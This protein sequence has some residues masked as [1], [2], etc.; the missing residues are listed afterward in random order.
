MLHTVCNNIMYLHRRNPFNGKYYRINIHNENKY[1]TYSPN[2]FNKA[3][4]DNSITPMIVDPYVCAY[5]DTRFS[6]RNKLFY[7]LGYMGINIF[8][9]RKIYFDNREK[10]KR[11]WR[12]KK[13]CSKND[14]II[15][16]KR[17][18]KNID[19]VIRIL[20]NTSIS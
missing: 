9:D 11:T 18:R 14:E 15:P 12:S 2:T 10:R 16:T 17:L 8:N 3:V 5:C 7:H 19:E 20:S 4:H 1:M 6:S 13:Y